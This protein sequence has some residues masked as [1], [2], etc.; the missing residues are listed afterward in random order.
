M[1]VSTRDIAEQFDWLRLHGWQPVSLAQIVAAHEGRAAL[2]PRA[3]LLTFDDSLHSRVFPL[4]QAYGYPA[5]VAIQTDWLDRVAAGERVDYEDGERG[6]EGFVGWDALREMLASG[7]VEVA[8]HSHDLHRGLQGNPQ[9]N[10]QPAATTLAYDPATGRYESVAERAQR[11][12]EDLA[13]SADALA[14]ELG[15]RP[16]AIVWPYGEYDTLAESIAAELGMVVSLGLAT[17][18]NT[19]ASL[20]GLNRL[21]ITGNPDLGRFALN[22]PQ[23]PVREVK[24]AVR[25]ALHEVHHA[26]AAEQARRLDALVE[27]I[28]RLEISAVYLQAYATGQGGRIEAAFFPNRHL[29]VRADLFSHVAWQLR[30]RAGVQ[31]YAA[32]PVAPT[33]LPGGREA[34]RELY[35]DLARHAHFAGLAFTPLGTPLGSDPEA[36]LESMNLTEELARAVR[37]YRPAVRT[38]LDLT[39]DADP[40]APGHAG[41]SWVALQA[42]HD[43]LLLPLGS[44]P[45]TVAP[46]TPAFHPT[47]DLQRAVFVLPARSPQGWVPEARLAA[48]LAAMIRAGALNLA[49]APDDFEQ[50]RPRAEPMFR[51]LSRRTFPYRE[52]R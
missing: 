51:A 11:L 17:G 18:P 9:G 12:R 19:L 34:L 40:S 35:E 10:L 26:D 15:Q 50:D 37:Q 46:G 44:D 4:L 49:Y 36:T 32:M 24:R 16:R 1:A 7:L 29:P 13:R 28:H 5:L 38:A 39:A 21:L 20:Q 47:L 41:L 22:V 48:Q 8:S 2:P 52:A 23:Q 33:S 30:T 25:V 6:P 43:H 14:R 31:V 42:R 27:R 3:V 45:E